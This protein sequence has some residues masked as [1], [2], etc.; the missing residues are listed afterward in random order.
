MSETEGLTNLAELI[1]LNNSNAFGSRSNKIYEEVKG[2][3]DLEPLRD[4]RRG[5]R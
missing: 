3:K 5:I 1:S 4:A 2:P